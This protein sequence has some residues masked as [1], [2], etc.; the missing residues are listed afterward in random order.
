MWQSNS[1][2]VN[3][4][5]VSQDPSL[6]RNSIKSVPRPNAL[7]SYAKMCEWKQ[8]SKS[9]QTDLPATLKQNFYFQFHQFQVNPLSS[10]W[11]HCDSYLILPGP[12]M[13][14]T[15]LCFWLVVFVFKWF[16]DHFSFDH[17]SFT[18]KYFLPLFL[19]S[20]HLGFLLV[21][22]PHGLIPT[23]PSSFCLFVM[24]FL[25]SSTSNPQRITGRW[26]E[27]CKNHKAE[28]NVNTPQ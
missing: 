23:S 14:P 4:A 18:P 26:W 13:C 9:K 1:W 5:Q 16:L 7:D 15:Y 24:S 19:P 27:Q 25:F 11:D 8:P 21:P 22:G 17:L 6:Y 10:V 20:V 2:P 3:I 12:F 28:D